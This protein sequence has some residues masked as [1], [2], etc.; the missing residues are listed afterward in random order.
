MLRAM[1]TKNAAPK[2]KMMNDAR[3]RKDMRSLSMRMVMM[4]SGPDVE[5][6]KSTC[7]VWQG[8]GG[9][10]EVG[11]EDD[12]DQGHGDAAGLRDGA[13]EGVVD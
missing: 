7:R 4:S 10:G 11:A 9:A 5:K 3:R 2:A 1:S 12:E 13:G 8:E 6:M